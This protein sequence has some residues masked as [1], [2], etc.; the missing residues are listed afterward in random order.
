MLPPKISH[1]AKFHRDGQTAW[2][3][4]LKSV[5]FSVLPDIFFVTDG[6]KRDYL[7]RASQHAR[8]ASNKSSSMACTAWRAGCH[9]FN[10]SWWNENDGK[11]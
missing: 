11:L 6:Q 4:V 1:H 5:T 9:L 3:K 2:R 10:F 7:S 8:G